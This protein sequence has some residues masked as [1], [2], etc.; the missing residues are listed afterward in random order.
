M[1]HFLL[2][3]FPFFS[4]FFVFSCFSYSSLKNKWFGYLQN[5]P[6]LSLSILL[7]FLFFLLPLFSSLYPLFLSFFLS[8]PLS[9]PLFSLFLLLSIS[10]VILS[11]YLNCYLIIL[12]QLNNHMDSISRFYIRG[13]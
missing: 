2:F 8:L 11:F 3:S 4:C 7:N 12:S 5:Y 13:F 10:I 1:I 6:S 9:S